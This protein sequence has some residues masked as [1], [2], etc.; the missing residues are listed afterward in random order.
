[1]C[2]PGPRELRELVEWAQKEKKPFQR[3]MIPWSNRH[4]TYGQ[5]VYE[6]EPT[7]C[8]IIASL[9]NVKDVVSISKPIQPCG[10]NANPNDMLWPNFPEDTMRWIISEAYSSLRRWV[11]PRIP[12]GQT[13]LHDFL[14]SKGRMNTK[15]AAAMVHWQCGVSQE[16][17]M[18]CMGLS[19]LEAPLKFNRY[20]L[21]MQWTELRPIIVGFLKNEAVEDMEDLEISWV[22][23]CQIKK[24]NRTEF[25]RLWLNHRI[26]ILLQESSSDKLGSIAWDYR[27]TLF[28]AS[29]ITENE[30]GET[31]NYIERSHATP[32]EIL[33]KLPLPL[34]EGLLDVKLRDIRPKVNMEDE[35]QY[36]LENVDRLFK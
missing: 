4:L 21:G 20:P 7:D 14:K 32:T 23:D 28:P 30:N 15:A 35:F 1:M 26:P 29:I 6:G 9:R 8:E 3:A 2:D 18:E 27:S 19:D 11:L 22:D 5:F 13:G 31:L 33:E 36:L 25:I 16:Q 12:T 17:F 34:P 24:G 10:F